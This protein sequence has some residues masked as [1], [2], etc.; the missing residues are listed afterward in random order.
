MSHHPILL[1]SCFALATPRVIHHFS[2]SN[3]FIEGITFELQTWA[4]HVAAGSCQ[5]TVGS[6]GRNSPRHWASPGDHPQSATVSASCSSCSRGGSGFGLSSE[7]F[8]SAHSK[9]SWSSLGY[10]CCSGG[11]IPPAARHSGQC[12]GSERVREQEANSLFLGV[13]GLCA[14]L[15][16]VC[17]GLLLL[18]WALNLTPDAQ[19]TCSTC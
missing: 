8:L 18:Q 2:S 1:T 17:E 6:R 16:E 7:V 5:G 15:L 4:A 14:D 11:S 13:E 10:K 3:N 12:L 9:Q 19:L